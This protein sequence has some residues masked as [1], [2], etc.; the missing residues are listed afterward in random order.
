MALLSGAF[1]DVALMGPGAVIM[2]SFT[3]VSGLTMEADFEVFQEGGS[4]Y[5]RFFFNQ[6]KPQV[7]VLEQGVVTSF[8]SVSLLMGMVNMGMS[9]PMSGTVMLKD[10]FGSIQRMWTI[11][12]AHLQRYIGPD[13]NSN[14]P[15]LAVTRM[16]LLYNGCY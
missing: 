15:S 10:R 12:G 2:G 11:V 8:D 5:P 16:E 14:Q 3:S 7:L 6:V 1:F 4:L 9:I 13:L